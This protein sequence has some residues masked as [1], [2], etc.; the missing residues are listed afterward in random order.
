MRSWNRSTFGI[1]PINR[2]DDQEKVCLQT[3]NMTP[4]NAAMGIRPSLCSGELSGAP[5]ARVDF[6]A[7]PSS[8][9]AETRPAARP[10]AMTIPL[11]RLVPPASTL[12]SDCPIKAQPPWPPVNP[13][14]K[15]P[16]PWPM[17]SW[18]VLPLFPSSAMPS[19]NCKVKQA[20]D[21]CGNQIHGAFFDLSTPSHDICSMAWRCRFLTT[22]RQRGHVIAEP[23]WLALHQADARHRRRVGQHHLQEG[24]RGGLQSREG[25]RHFE[26][27]Q[28][29]Q[30]AGE[31]LLARQIG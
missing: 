31:G 21:L 10:P 17:H 14:A 23:H 26:R 6:H 1:L 3:R 24:S 30:S 16:S 4:T 20:L 18:R 29:F 22:R 11:K 5:D 2:N 8:G 7:G 19:T 25:R 13:E 12:I 28:D 15:F 9:A 27:R